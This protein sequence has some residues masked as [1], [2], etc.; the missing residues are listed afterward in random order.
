MLLQPPVRRTADGGVRL[1]PHLD[2]HNVYRPQEARPRAGSL[3]L[4]QV[5]RAAEQVQ[6]R[7]EHAGEDSITK[8]LESE[9]RLHKGGFK[10]GSQAD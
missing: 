10:K 7:Q 5:R 6:G 3:A 1:V 2:P 9:R 4:L 8:L